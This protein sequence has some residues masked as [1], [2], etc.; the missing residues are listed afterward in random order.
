VRPEL[1]IDTEEHPPEESA[2]IVL[3]KLEQ[4]GL[5]RAEVAA[6]VSL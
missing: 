5:T 6:E 2:H 3:E 4:L 1:R